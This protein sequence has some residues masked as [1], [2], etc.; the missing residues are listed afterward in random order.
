M[1]NINNTIKAYFIDHIEAINYPF[2]LISGVEI[3][4]N[5]RLY[6]FPQGIFD[7][8]PVRLVLFSFDGEVLENFPGMKEVSARWDNLPNLLP[9]E[10][11]MEEVNLYQEAYDALLQNFSYNF[12]GIELPRIYFAYH[13]SNYSD[14]VN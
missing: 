5:A 13:D 1:S 3:I 12:G 9:E 4:K 10:V 6:F 7:K 14:A 2:D 8:F 11:F